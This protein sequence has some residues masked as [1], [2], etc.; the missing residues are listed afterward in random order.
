MRRRDFLAGVGGAAAWP[1]AAGA[2][3]A[4][5]MPQIAVLMGLPARDPEGQRWIRTFIQGL[6]DLGWRNG[7]NVNIELRWAP[8][9]EQMRGFAQELVALQPDVIQVATGLAT[10]EVLRKTSTI[11]LVFTVVNDPV[12]LGF[13]Q[14]L[15]RPGGNATG[16]TNI[17]PSLGQK[18]LEVLKETAPRLTRA[19]VMFNPVPGSQFKYRWPQIEAAGAAL[20]LAAEA[21]EVRNLAEFEK[22]LDA[23]GHD[24]Q[25]GLVITPDQYFNLTR[26]P[27]ITAL[28]SRYRVAAIYP[29]RDFAT[30]GGLVSY[31]VDLA[32]L[33]RRAAGYVNRILKG[34]KPAD[35]PVQAPAKFDLVINL[36]TAKTLGLTIAPALRARA[37]EV[38]E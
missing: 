8:N 29:Y 12:A 35:L 32:D 30:A 31:S 24:P 18:W 17:D 13:V 22:A 2:Q 9:I 1:L 34:E 10:A 20:G 38:V 23:I 21:V 19:K 6:R 37:D 4:A 5:R 16:F 7:T 14:D 3:P 36:K 33:Q 25:T 26:A 27:V 11:P 28:V 15:S